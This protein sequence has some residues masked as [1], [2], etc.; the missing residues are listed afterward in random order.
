LAHPGTARQRYLA[1][2]RVGRTAARVLQIALEMPMHI[3]VV[4]ACEWR[5]EPSECAAAE[6]R[7]AW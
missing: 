5:S 3:S 1:A 2:A 7:A 4:V 6:P